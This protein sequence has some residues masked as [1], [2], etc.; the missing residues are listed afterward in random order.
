MKTHKNRKNLATIL[1]QNLTVSGDFSV[2]Q[3]T[4]KTR[5]PVPRRVSWAEDTG[6]VGAASRPS[7]VRVQWYR[8]CSN[9][10]V[11]K[12]RR[13]A[14]QS[15]KSGLRVRKSSFSSRKSSGSPSFSITIVRPWCIRT[16]EKIRRNGW[17]PPHRVLMRWK[18]E[19]GRSMEIISSDLPGQVLA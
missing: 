6:G 1:L 8:K 12:L 19:Y 11:K 10:A 15:L 5:T 16:W 18:N 3:L 13:C 9:L 7:P 4:A 17:Q 2:R 14:T